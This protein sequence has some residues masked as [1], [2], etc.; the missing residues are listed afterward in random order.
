MGKFVDDVFVVVVD[1]YMAIMTPLRPRMGRIV[2]LSLAIAT[3][4]LGAI[5]SSPNLYVYTTFALPER[6][7]CYSEWPDGLTGVSKLDY[8]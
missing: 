4:V 2:T 8:M 7:I 5:I 6:I 3:W 1:R